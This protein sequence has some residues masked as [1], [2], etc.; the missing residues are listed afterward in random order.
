MKAFL[1]EKPFG[2]D[3]T[4]HIHVSAIVNVKHQ[5]IFRS[6]LGFCQLH[7]EPALYPSPFL[8]ID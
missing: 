4:Y 5:F 2:T 6:I 7:V 3:K 1:Y 8:N